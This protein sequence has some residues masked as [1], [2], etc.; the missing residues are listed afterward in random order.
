MATRRGQFQEFA[1][2]VTR[3]I[4]YLVHSNVFI[5]LAATSVVVSTVILA[6]L[7]FDPVALFIVFAVTMFVYSF[8]RITDIAED[9]QNIPGRASFIRRYGK[10]LLAIGTALYLVATGVAIARDI[11]YAPGMLIP[12]LVAVLYSVVGLKRVLLVKNLL[13]GL[14]WGLIPLGVGVYYDQLGSVDILFMAVFVT[15]M[16]TIAAAIFDIKDIEGDSEAGIDTL[17]VRYSAARTRQ[18]AAG[19]TV[20]VSIVVVALVVADVLTRRYSLLLTFTGY[21]FCYCLVARRD[22]GPLFYGFV[23]DGEH[24]FLALILLGHEVLV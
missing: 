21:V 22:R 14:S 23:V 20:L 8:N 11:P 10:A 24:I 9:T 13:V 4:R 5:S 17:P 2:L 18:I 6:D 7:S 1:M 15:T 16:I 3:S 19:A 12:M